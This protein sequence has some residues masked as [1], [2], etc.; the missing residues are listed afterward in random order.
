MKCGGLTSSCCLSNPHEKTDDKERSRRIISALLNEI[1]AAT[2]RY[3]NQTLVNIAQMKRK[4]ITFDSFLLILKLTQD[5][6]RKCTIKRL[7]PLLGNR[8]S[9]GAK[10]FFILCSSGVIN[11]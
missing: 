4:P 6:V 11:V 2:L 9:H 3:G 10:T 8:A 7:K 5:Q 1:Q